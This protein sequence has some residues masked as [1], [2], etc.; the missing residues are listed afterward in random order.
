LKKTKEERN[1]QVGDLI[2]D[3]QIL[4]I[5]SNRIIIIRANGQQETLYLREEDAAFDFNKEVRFEPRLIVEE[6]ID[7]TYIINI[8]EFTYKIPNLGEFINA[9]DVT[10]VYKQGKSFGCRVGRI[11]KDSLGELLGFQ[12]N[13]I[14]IKVD[15]LPVDDVN[16]RL[17]VYDHMIHKRAG[18]S[19]VVTV[20]RGQDEI[21]LQYGLIDKVMKSMNVTPEQ[22][23]KRLVQELDKHERDHQ[24]SV[25]VQNYI[26][27]QAEQDNLIDDSLEEADF[28]QA[29]NAAQNDYIQSFSDQF[30]TQHRLPETLH[31]ADTHK[32]KIV[33]EQEHFVS[34]SEKLR[35]RDRNTMRQNSK[36]IILGSM[37]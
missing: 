25:I 11:E 21:E 2:E 32:K 26:P 9:L 35:D 4:K 19:V 17:A 31:Q 3:A 6:Q 24:A 14:I 15:D 23:H 16:H 10:T 8:D 5:L 20:L 18:S 13:D 12:P 7:S 22:L 1:Y 34:I 33:A 37:Q 30:M 29:F 28:E 36:N 27:E